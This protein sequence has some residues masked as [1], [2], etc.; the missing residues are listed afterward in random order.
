MSKAVLE[1]GTAFLIDLAFGL[2]F[3]VSVTSGTASNHFMDNSFRCFSIMFQVTAWW[4][5]EDL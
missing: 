3:S 2:L 4:V 1:A 5:S